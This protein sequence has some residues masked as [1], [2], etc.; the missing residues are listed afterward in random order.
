M[1][2]AAC[3]RLESVDDALSCCELGRVDLLSAKGS[4]RAVCVVLFVRGVV[5]VSSVEI[6]DFFH[7][8]PGCR[9]QAGGDFSP[10]PGT[11]KQNPLIGVL[12]T[13][14]ATLPDSAEPVSPRALA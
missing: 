8:S 11:P 7:L 9:A 13:H 1:D 12:G 2:P 4:R 10:R 3:L 14:R 6:V 5:V